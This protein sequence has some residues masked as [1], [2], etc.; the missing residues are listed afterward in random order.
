MTTM[1]VKEVEGVTA[2]AW[3]LRF[4]ARPQGDGSTVFRVW[5]PRAESLAVKILC[6]G[7]R[8][9]PLLASGEGVFEARVPEVA[10]GADYFY[11][12]N[13]NERPD[14]VSRFQPAGVHGPSRVVAP[15]E[16]KWTDKDWKGLALKNYVVYELHAGTF[17]S[18]GT[19]ESIIPRLAHLK[20]LGVTAVELM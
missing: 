18:E 9:F 11:V 1:M 15:V 20:S 2:A 14:P 12:V 7:P 16:F 8:T 17:T 6:E 10:A 4:G 13:G 3:E 19:F 5:A